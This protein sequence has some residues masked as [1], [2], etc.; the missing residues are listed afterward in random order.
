M[1]LNIQQNYTVNLPG[2]NH[3]SANLKNYLLKIIY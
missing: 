3:R 2:K 1:A